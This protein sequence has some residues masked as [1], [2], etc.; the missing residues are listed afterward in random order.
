MRLAL[1]AKWYFRGPPSGRRV[2]QSLL[3][4]LADAGEPDDRIALILRSES[5]AAAANGLAGFD[6]VF[7]PNP[8]PGW[9]NLVM[10]N[11]WI[12]K[13]GADLG[14]FQNFS[15]IPKGDRAAV[16]IYD[17]IFATHPQ[18]FTKRERAYFAP[19]LSSARGARAI[20]TI[21]RSERDRLL[22]L[23]LAGEDRIFSVPLGVSGF[24]RPRD[25]SDS[26]GLEGEAVGLRLPS[27]YVLFCGRV[28]IRK[29]IG[30]LLRALLLMGKGAIPLV[31]VGGR[32]WRTE[33]LRELMLAL[34]AQRRLLQ[35]EGLSE[36]ALLDVYQRATVFAYPSWAEGFGLP[37]LEAMSCGTPVVVSDL[38]VHREVCFD[39]ALFVP[40]GSP[41]AIAEAISRCVNDDT[42]RESMRK[43]GLARAQHYTWARTAD[44]MWR[45]LR[46]VN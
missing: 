6:H 32:D 31:V 21:S 27:E 12:R 15:P 39:A 19:I 10:G 40:P 43:A 30:N 44:E 3:Q 11:K 18:F 20:L 36:L 4:G 42:L 8:L 9:Q 22:G 26:D 33:E 5:R 34:A 28:N 16:L 13:L 29:N 7:A 46:E 38:P 24:F 17:G 14:L 41:E 23:G 2:V 45:V 35:M 37:P 25:D 1:D